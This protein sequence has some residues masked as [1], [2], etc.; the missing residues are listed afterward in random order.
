MHYILQGLW[1]LLPVMVDVVS[2]A[3]LCL[4]GMVV[5][6]LAAYFC[7]CWSLDSVHYLVSLSSIRKS[8]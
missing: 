8:L 1:P 7:A 3:V 4:L 5:V 2:L 6:S